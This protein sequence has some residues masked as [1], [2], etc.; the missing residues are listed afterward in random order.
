M[1]V[2]GVRKLNSVVSAQ[3]KDFGIKR[4]V[5]SDEYCYM[6]NKEEVQFKLTTDIEDEWLEEFIKERFGYV[7][8]NI[9]IISL[10][11]EVGHHFTY[12]DVDGSVL[13]FCEDEKARI[14]SEIVTASD[15]RSKALEWEY[16]NLPDEIVATAWAVKYAREHEDEMVEKWN[17][18]AVALKEFY[19]RNGLTP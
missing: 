5:L 4:A 9:F 2:K 3:L 13:S 15:E 19:E 14:E 7:V 12:D 18:I 11:H 1:K 17:T 16:F 10:L 8:P 6:C